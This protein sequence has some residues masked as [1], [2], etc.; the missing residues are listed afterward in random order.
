MLLFILVI[1]QP[2]CYTGIA[3]GL[4]IGVFFVATYSVMSKHERVIDWRR[5]YSLDKD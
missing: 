2:R 1:V 4:F 5:E 3:Y